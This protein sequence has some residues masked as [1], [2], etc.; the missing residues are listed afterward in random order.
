[1]KEKDGA[2]AR[3]RRKERRMRPRQR[4][5]IRTGQRSEKRAKSKAERVSVFFCGEKCGERSGK[6]KREEWK[7]HKEKKCR[8]DAEKAGEGVQKAPKSR[9]SGRLCEKDA[10]TAKVGLSGEKTADKKQKKEKKQEMRRGIL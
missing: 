6:R 1:M 7:T 5:P 10:K 4:K 8:Y 3:N 9:G 2:R